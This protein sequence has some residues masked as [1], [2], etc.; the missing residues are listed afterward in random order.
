MG[1]QLKQ[2]LSDQKPDRVS[3]NQTQAWI[4]ASPYREHPGPTDP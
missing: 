4:V 3:R 2:M 1:Q